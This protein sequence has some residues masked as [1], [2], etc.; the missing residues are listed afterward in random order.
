[1]RTIFLA[2]TSNQVVGGSNPSGRTKSLLS[3]LKRF[4]NCC[5]SI[6]IRTA[7]RQQDRFDSAAQR[8]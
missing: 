4:G 1:M 6:L 2:T 7:D 5:L 3:Q 8:R